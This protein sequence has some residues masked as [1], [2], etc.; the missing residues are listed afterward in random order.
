MVNRK[1]NEMP[2]TLKTGLLIIGGTLSMAIGILGIF[3]PVLPTTPFLLLAAAC[4]MSS[5]QKL[6]NW[7][8][9]N[10]FVGAYISHYIQGKGIPLKV[11]LFTVIFLWITI[12]LS[13]VFAV[14]GVVIRVVLILVAVGVTTHIIRITT[15][16]G[17]PKEVRNEKS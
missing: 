15:L 16:R 8:L 17:N 5:S 4:Y 13:V 12:G 7:L 3:V 9:S 6:Y 2:N 14:Q 11:K 10:R 1:T